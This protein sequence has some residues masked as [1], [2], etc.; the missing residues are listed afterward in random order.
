MSWQQ[1]G[2]FPLIRVSLGIAH[3]PQAPQ[4]QSQTLPGVL[5]TGVQTIGFQDSSHIPSS[6][7]LR[8]RQTSV[9]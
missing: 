5:T 9:L 6:L 3:S 1:A 2:M 7:H 8:L 4:S